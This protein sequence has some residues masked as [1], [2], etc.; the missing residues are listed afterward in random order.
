ML[1]S[2]LIL[3]SGLIALN[4]QA[5]ITYPATPKEDVS[6]EYYG[7]KV[8]EPY[9]WLENDRSP[10][11]EAWVKEENKITQDYLLKIPFRNKLKDRLT[12][13]L[14]YPKY[15]SPSKHA[16]KYYFFK[17]NGLQNQS[18][19]FEL[20]DLNSEPQVILDPNTLSADGTVALST[21][22]FSKNGKYLAYSIARS[23]SDWNEI[24]VMDVASRKQVADHLEWVKFSGISWEK[25][26][27]YYSAYSKPEGGKELSG[28]NE[29]HKVFYHKLGTDQ[30]Q[31][32]LIF[33]DKD[34]PLRN[35]RVGLTD[36][37][38]F[39]IISQSESTS[40][41]SLYLK[42]LTD[43]QS[44]IQLVAPGFDFDYSI[45]EHYNGKLYVLTNRNADNQQLMVMDPANPSYENWTTLI[46][47]SSN[48]MESVSILGG[49]IFVKYMQDASHHLYAYNTN[50]ENLY[51]VKLPSTGTVGIQGDLDDNEAFYSFSSYTTPLTIYKYNVA[52]NTAQIFRSPEVK[53]NPEDYVSE[54]VFY[55]SKDGTRVPLNIIYKKGIKLDGKNPL[56]LYGYGG[57]NISLNPSFTTSRLPFIENGG[58]YVIAN[59]RGGGEY[60]EDWHLAGTKLKKQN[61]FDDF[62]A[63]AEY[64]I[65]KGYTSS[66][67][68]AIDGGSNGGLLV[69]ACMTQRPDLFAV[70]VPE[71]GVLDMLRYQ[72]FTIGWAWATDYGTVD[73]SKE[74]FEYLLG[75]SPLHNLKKGVQYPATLVM[76]GDHD[77]R[78][79]PAHSFKFAATLQSVQ[80]GKNPTLIRIDTNAGHGAG[81]PTAKLI[82]AQ[83]DMWSF[84]MFNLGMKL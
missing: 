51:E 11:T 27:F 41:N 79:V 59:I 38:K 83:A 29:F 32:Q 50:G 40:G 24:F 39:L 28:K 10:E 4:M 71:V 25:D 54:Q 64:L 67:R 57:F 69:G 3:I 14:N 44:K 13:L 35:C 55:T 43:P 60:G 62:I 70:C 76:T 61:V 65:Q 17:N 74:M 9:R 18:V 66:S 1:K 15:G 19:L 72:K 52:E 26:G 46:P 58:I 73:D 77:D 16:G 47:E 33:E 12:E 84:V 37:E 81:K 20:T 80:T 7:T 75:Y 78:V 48:V 42:D 2:S 45:V 82:D 36:D 63:A 6:E 8:N 5:K 68:L 53:F 56:L 21:L 49:K 30:S 22:S 23:G 31:D 34:H